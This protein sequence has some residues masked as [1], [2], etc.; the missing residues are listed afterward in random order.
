MKSCFR[1]LSTERK[2]A[3]AR[4]FAHCVRINFVEV[5]F[6]S[7]SLSLFLGYCESAYTR[8]NEVSRITKLTTSIVYGEI[9]A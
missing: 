1:S 5:S 9:I 8:Y 3:G 2:I 7:L 4:A 6:S